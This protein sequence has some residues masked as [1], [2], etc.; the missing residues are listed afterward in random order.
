MVRIKKS[1]FFPPKDKALARKISIRTPGEF[2]KSISNLR[3]NGFTLKE[4]RAL[5]LARTRAKV[6]LKRKNLSKRE[7][8]QMRA[9]AN[10]TIPRVTR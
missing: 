4:K 7:R 2:R 5:V 6:Q 8:K 10:T 1:I 3:K 9:I